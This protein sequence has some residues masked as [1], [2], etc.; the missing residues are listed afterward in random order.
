MNKRLQLKNKSRPDGR[1]LQKIGKL[2]EVLG[3]GLEQ[4]LVLVAGDVDTDELAAAL[5]VAHLTEDAAVG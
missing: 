1:L 4:R 2:L 3:A 5:G